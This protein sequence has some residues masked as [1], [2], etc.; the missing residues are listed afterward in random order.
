ME[1]RDRYPLI[2]DGSEHFS[3]IMAPHDHFSLTLMGPEHMGALRIDGLQQ[4]RDSI[5]KPCIITL[6]TGRPPASVVVLADGSTAMALGT[7]GRAAQ[8]GKIDGVQTVMELAPAHATAALSSPFYVGTDIDVP[9]SR[10]MDDTMANFMF[11]EVA[12]D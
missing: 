2:L 11:V 9:M 8:I 10:F 5:P 3:I 1:I 6:L 7:K 12:N 4:R